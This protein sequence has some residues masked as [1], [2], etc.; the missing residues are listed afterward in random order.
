MSVGGVRLGTCATG[1]ARRPAFGSESGGLQFLRQLRRLIAIDGG[2]GGAMADERRRRA[3]GDMRDGCGETP[4]IRI[5]VG[6]LTGEE[7]A[8]LQRAADRG[9]LFVRLPPRPWI[10]NAV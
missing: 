7:R 10:G 2:V 5:G 4:R 6:R 3:A 8:G 1:A 9:P